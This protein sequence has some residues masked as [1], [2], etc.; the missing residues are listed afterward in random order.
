MK[1]M[2]RERARKA[3][4]AKVLAEAIKGVGKTGSLTLP[5]AIVLAMGLPKECKGGRILTD[6][7]LDANEGTRICE[8]EKDGVTYSFAYDEGA[9]PFGPQRMIDITIV[10]TFN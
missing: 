1:S 9:N 7:I 5:V 3:K 8:Y 10:G 4:A 6:E 2:N